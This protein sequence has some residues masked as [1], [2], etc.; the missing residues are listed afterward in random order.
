MHIPSLAELLKRMTELGGSDLHLAVGTHPQVR[1][2]G[3]L[4]PLTE[5]P[6]LTAEDTRRLA[7]SLLTPTRS[8]TWKNIWSSTSP[9]ALEGWP[10]FEATAS[11]SGAPWGPSFDAFP[12]RSAASTPSICRRY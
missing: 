6:F 10:G 12:T 2:D 9:L 7:Y 1:V 8:S 11:T 4:R 3:R 5:F